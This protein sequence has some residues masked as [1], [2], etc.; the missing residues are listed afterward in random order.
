MTT[1]DDI[2]RAYTSV[3]QNPLSLN[4]LKAV[5]DDIAGNFSWETGVTPLSEPQVIIVSVAFSSCL[6][7]W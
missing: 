5:Y 4:H 3:L 7:D 2:S 1:L 6:F